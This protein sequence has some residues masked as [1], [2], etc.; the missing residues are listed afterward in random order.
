M[1]FLNEE[2]DLIGENDLDG[3]LCQ[4]TKFNGTEFVKKEDE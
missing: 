3:S 1:E 2:K 4:E